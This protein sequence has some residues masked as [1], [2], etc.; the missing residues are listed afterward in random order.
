MGKK[1]L[2]IGGGGRE[3]AIVK[4]LSGCPSV[5]SIICS[6]GN[7]GTAG[8]KN[9]LNIP[10]R[11]NYEI[12]NLAVSE[13]VDLV[14][15]GPE[16]PLAEGLVNVLNHAGIAAFGPPAESALLESS[17][18]FA[19]DFM[20]R[21]GVATADY[22]V[23]TSP[24]KAKA[25]LDSFGFPVVIKADGL[26]A[27]KGVLICS[28]RAEAEAAVD[29]ILVDRDFGS[30]GDQL[31]LEQCLV[32]WE[33]S[34]IGIVDG[35]SFLPFLPAKDHKRAGDGDTGLNTGGMGV[36]APHPL[37]DDA[38]MDDIIENII[39]PT[40]SGLIEEELGYPG[41]LFIG[42]MVTSEGAKTLEYN[43]RLGDPE[44]QALLPLLAGD[45]SE[46]MEIALDERLSEI[47]PEWWTGASCCVVM[48]SEGY[49]GS[50]DTGCTITG[51][52]DAEEKGA[53]VYCAGVKTGESETGK[54]EILI[55]DG[56]RVLGVTA[57]GDN[58]EDACRKAYD[59]VSCIK[60]DGAWYRTDI[61]S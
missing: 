15:P 22:A 32:G 50:Y 12:L 56:G 45:L 39:E 51:I 19:K 38:V 17:K 36:I 24:L 33:T 46:Y 58:I 54:S 60:F 18:G 30:A 23:F 35:S 59:S 42:V 25:A 10:A 43:V 8:V 3:H 28:D 27:G 4:S 11:G 5:D 44:A 40:M 29:S 16:I 57:L 49:P 52:D 1:V 47:E 61:G 20:A 55:S 48:A 2:V 31:I 41:F 21:N 37:V 9:C 14:V 13:D 34:I 26:A 6:P 53:Q 7:A